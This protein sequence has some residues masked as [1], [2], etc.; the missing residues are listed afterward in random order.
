MNLTTILPHLLYQFSGE[1]ELA[2]S[3]EELSVKFTKDRSRIGDYLKDPRLVS[4]YTAFYLLTNLPKF[5]AVHPWLPEDWLADLKKAH[6]IDVGA[7]PGTFSLAY[8]LWGGEGELLQV[9]IS[10]LMKEQSRRLFAGLYPEVKL[11]QMTRWTNPK[12]DG[13]KLLFFGH[14]ANEMGPELVLDLINQTR[15]EH[16]LF[17]E[18][19]TKEFFPKMLAIRNELLK[20]GYHVLYPCPTAATCPMAGDTENWCHQFIQVK[21]DPEVERLSQIVSKDRSLLPLTVQ[22]FSLKTYGPNPQERIVRVLPDT[23]FSFE[24]QVCHTNELQNYQIMKKAYSKS[25]VK[26]LLK[27]LAGA[28]IETETEKIL[29]K[30][31]RVRLLR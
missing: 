24:W 4:A 18:P 10:D 12:L 14:S 6:L 20:S 8:K 29:E 19:G 3:I 5:E 30:S 15:A 22:A 31:K 28:S 23:K 13:E 26:E 21:H 25:E 11:S 1:H 7:G 2:R 9:E 17:I 27:V 16:V